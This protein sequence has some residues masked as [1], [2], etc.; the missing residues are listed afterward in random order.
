MEKLFELIELKINKSKRET[1]TFENVSLGIKEYNNF[2]DVLE[3]FKNVVEVKTENKIFISSFVLNIAPQQKT[4]KV[5]I[6][7]PYLKYKK[8]VLKEYKDKNYIINDNK[9]K[10]A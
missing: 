8:E 1:Q 6:Y 2:K 4:V 10:T 9:D 7:T 5:L 3:E